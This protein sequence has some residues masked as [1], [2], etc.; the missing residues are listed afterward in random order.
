ML[1]MVDSELVRQAIRA[2]WDAG[3]F[4]EVRAPSLPT[5]WPVREMACGSSNHVE[6]GAGKTHRGPVPRVWRI[7]LCT[8]FE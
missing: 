6:A 3:R 8:V 4:R 1:R 5:G 7:R 2:F